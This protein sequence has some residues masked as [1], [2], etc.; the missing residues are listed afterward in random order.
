MLVPQPG[1]DWEDV[2]EE[3]VEDSPPARERLATFFPLEHPILPT[4]LELDCT[5]GTIRLRRREG[6]PVGKVRPSRETAAALFVQAAS[7]LLFLGSRGFPLELADF[8]DGR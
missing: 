7:A 8:E 4:F 6:T 3:T 5:A 2:S 1:S